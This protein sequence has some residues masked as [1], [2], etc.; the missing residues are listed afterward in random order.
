MVTWC[1]LG[2]IPIP[3]GIPSERG[4]GGERWVVRVLGLPVQGLGLSSRF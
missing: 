4:R 1:L 3:R 2:D